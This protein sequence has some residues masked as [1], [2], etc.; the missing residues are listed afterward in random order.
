MDI[1]LIEIKENLNR[2]LEIAKQK[3]AQEQDV[4]KFQEERSE[5]SGRIS[6]F[7]LTIKKHITKHYPVEEV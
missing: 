1:P 3:V 7:L 6:G 4:L 2:F 5:L